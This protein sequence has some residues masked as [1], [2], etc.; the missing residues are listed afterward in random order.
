MVIRRVLT[1]ITIAV[2]IGLIILLSLT[3]LSDEREDFVRSTHVQ[4]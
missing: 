2:S 1:A 3:M 4:R